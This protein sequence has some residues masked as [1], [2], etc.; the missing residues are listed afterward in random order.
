MRVIVVGAGLIG[1]SVAYALTRYEDGEVHVIEQGARVGGGASRGN[2]GWICPTQVAPLAGPGLVRRLARD[3]LAPSSALYIRPGG[4][5]ALA[6]FLLRLASGAT[7]RTY[8][9]RVAALQVLADRA[10][11][12]L[13]AAVADGLDVELHRTGI[14][15]VFSDTAIAGHALDLLAVPAELLNAA[16]LGEGCLTSRAKTGYLLREDGF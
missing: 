6:P 2:A 3:A 7:T 12:A 4:L 8:R 11:P 1:L 5:P 9:E 14:L 10:W 16:D 13:E 15:S